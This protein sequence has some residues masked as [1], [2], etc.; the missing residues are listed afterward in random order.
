MA[1]PPHEP[2]RPLTGA[3]QAALARLATHPVSLTAGAPAS[4]THPVVALDV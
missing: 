1:T 3:E 2:L 4:F